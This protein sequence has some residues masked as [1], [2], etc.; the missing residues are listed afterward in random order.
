MLNILAFLGCE[1]PLNSIFKNSG[2]EFWYIV[3]LVVKTSVKL[4][5]ISE[6]CQTAAD[7]YSVSV[8]AGTIKGIV[9]FKLIDQSYL[10]FKLK[11]SVINIYIDIINFLLKFKKINSGYD[12]LLIT[13]ITF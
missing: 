7:R 9:S 5:V 3:T 2:V 12:S 11:K 8:P 13:G 10:G 4:K 1:A 6:S